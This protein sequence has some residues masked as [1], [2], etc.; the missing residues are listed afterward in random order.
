MISVDTLT[1]G[2]RATYDVLMERLER[3][4]STDPERND[5]RS[6]YPV[7]DTFLASASRHVNAATAVLVPAARR[8]LP[9]G[10]ARGH[11]FVA[12]VR[13]LEAA[14]A[15][16]KARLYGSTYAIGRS[17]SSVWDDT[18]LELEATRRLEEE[19]CRDLDERREADD[20]DWTD[21]LYRAE[22]HAPTRPHPYV[23]H[24]GVGGRLAREVALRVDRFWDMAEGRMA[25]EP[26]RHHDRSHDGPL[27]QY[28]LADP[29]FDED[30]LD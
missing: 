2:T 12:Q 22:L 20:P 9:D 7:T 10:S 27:T 13:R 15:Q 19:L 24:Q 1:A 17:W 21:R 14:M 8:R 16:V 11:A 23:P 4:A 18:R 25:P 3:A 30:E 26:V 28:L 5:P 29:H 6:R